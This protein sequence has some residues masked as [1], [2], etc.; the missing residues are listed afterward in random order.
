MA[1]VLIAALCMALLFAVFKVFDRRGIPLLPAIVVNYFTAFGLGTVLTWPWKSEDVV[2]LLP[3]VAL[4][5]VLFISIFWIT[6]L[7]TQRI[8]VAVST[9]ASKMSLVLTVLFAVVIF[10]DRPGA[11]GWVGI[12]LAFVAVLASSWPSKRTGQV[13]SWWLPVVLFF[14]TA[15]VDITLNT[16]QREL[17]TSATSSLFPTLV[18]GVAGAIGLTTMAANKTLRSIGQRRV[19]I[20]GLVLGAINY[21]SLYFIL[22]ALARSGFPPS[23][24]FP[25]MNIG[26]VLFGTAISVIAFGERLRTIQWAGIACAVIAMALIMW[27]QQVT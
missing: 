9:V 23:S 6:G 18:F 21:A 15:A 1:L 5:G 12:V 13:R 7:A 17:L 3:A 14:G 27:A 10:G 2:P 20:G 4:V 25:L 8:G 22:G 16:V 19:L 11:L 26:V 24:V